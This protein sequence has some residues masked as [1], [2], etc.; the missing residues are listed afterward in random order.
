M[1]ATSSSRVALRRPVFP[2]SIVVLA[3][4]GL[5]A[6]GGG[7]SSSSGDSSSTLATDVAQSTTATTMSVPADS[8]E[9]MATLVSTSEVV[10]AGGTAGA[11]YACLGGGSAQFTVTGANLAQVTN[12]VLDAGEVYSLSFTHCRGSAGAA[13]VNGA[14]TLT[15]LGNGGGTLSVQT[16][17]QSLS[18]ALPLRTLTQTGQ[19]S[20]SRT[21]T[22]TGSTV[23]TT[24][25]WTASQITLTSVRSSGTTSSLALSG[26]DLTRSVTTSSGVLAGSSHQGKM[27]LAASAPSLNWTVTYATVGSVSYAADGTPTQGQ[28]TLTLP[29]HILGATLANGTATVTDDVG[30][31]GTV[32]HTFS[33]TVQSLQ[34]ASL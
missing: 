21:S 19:S 10:V 12:G 27:T 26:V 20:F 28:W 25:H 6:C 7:G 13:A 8:T 30:A 18:V 32:D 33:W 17:S 15:V 11:S 24:Q 14:L 3:C 5:T 34:N 9:A 16:S 4:A 1:N 31:D 23:Q 22:T 2:V 29:H